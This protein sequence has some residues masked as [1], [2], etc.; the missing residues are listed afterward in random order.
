MQISK[1]K[2]G[3]GFMVTENRL[4]LA[5]YINLINRRGTIVFPVHKDKISVQKDMKVMNQDTKVDFTSIYKQ[6]PLWNDG[7]ILLHKIPNS[8]IYVCLACCY[9]PDKKIDIN[10]SG[11]ESAMLKLAF[12]MKSDYYPIIVAKRMISKDY[13]GCLKILDYLFDEVVI[14]T[15][16]RN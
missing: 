14:N 12:T 16:D 11:F 4:S 13:N 7:D 8:N 15:F 6:R 5:K 2:G 1:F 3:F 9:I 10:L